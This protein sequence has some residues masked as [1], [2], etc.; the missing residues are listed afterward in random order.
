[1][2]LRLPFPGLGPP[3]SSALFLD[4]GQVYDGTPNVR[5]LRY[6]V[7]VGMRYQ[8]LVGFIRLDLGFKVNPS[9]IDLV[10]PEDLYLYRTGLK[11]ASRDDLP[12][13]FMRRFA[14]H[15]SI[16]QAF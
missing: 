7:G 9:L 12:R 16:G 10:D 11:Y 3:W 13:H 6:G 5:D 2:E 15:F 1:M 14:L 4:F 8:T